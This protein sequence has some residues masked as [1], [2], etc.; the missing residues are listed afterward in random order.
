MAD[1]TDN[2]N[3]SLLSTKNDDGK[4]A[5]LLSYSDENFTDALPC[6]NETLTI[7][8]TEGIKTIKIWKIDRENTNPYAEF[9]KNKWQENLTSEQ[10]EKLKN[11]AEI[12]AQTITIAHDGDICIDINITA[13]GVMLIEAE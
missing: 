12:K 2:E 1:S 4:I 10:I 3:V 11:I 13:N 7:G 8:G 6:L 5:V 9:E